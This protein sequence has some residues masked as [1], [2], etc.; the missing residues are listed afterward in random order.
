MKKLAGSGVKDTADGVGTAAQISEPRGLALSCDGSALLVADGPSVRQVVLEPPP[1]QQPI[2]IPPST[3]MA[4]M[5]K[6]WSADESE[7]PAGLVAFV[8]G[9]E[10]KR[11]DHVSK[12]NLCVRSEYFSSLF[13][14]GARE[15]TAAEVPVPDASPEAFG[16]MLKYLLTD[17]VDVHS[18]QHAYDTVTLAKMYLVPRLAVLC[19]KAI[20][21]RLAPTT[22]VPLLESAHAAGDARLL[23]KCRRV[24]LM[25]C[26]AVRRAGGV[27]RLRDLGLAKGLLCDAERKIDGMEGKSS[28]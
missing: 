20:E 21:D 6:L 14:S 19:L 23:Q 3:F 13:R 15:H 12:A 27:A 11:F 7:L 1:L 5:E 17:K 25:E 18:L 10:R 8:V 9:Q 28:S 2:E 24:V 4:D 22:A 16:S 26:S